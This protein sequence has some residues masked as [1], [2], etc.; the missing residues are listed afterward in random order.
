MQKLFKREENVTKIQ[1]INRAI[2]VS[3]EEI[4][5]DSKGERILKIYESEPVHPRRLCFDF[6]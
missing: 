3:I 4:N 6:Q 2:V 5:L 1:A